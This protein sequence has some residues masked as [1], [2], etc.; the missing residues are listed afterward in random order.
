MR[1]STNAIF[2]KCS[3][4]NEH[5]PDK[6]YRVNFPLHVANKYAR[7][8]FSFRK[9]L[10]HPLHTSS[11]PLIRSHFLH[12]FT[13]NLR[14][15]GPFIFQ[16]GELDLTIGYRSTGQ[17]DRRSNEQRDGRRERT[18]TDRHSP[19]GWGAAPYLGSA[20]RG[21]GLPFPVAS[22]LCVL[23]PAIERRF[24]DETMII[25]EYVAF[26]TTIAARDITFILR[27]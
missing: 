8:T 15:L 10:E 3:N 22:F 26:R 6:I 11:V 24:V 14:S 16:T 27:S 4:F 19:Y 25:Y 5:F 18:N 20:K 12:V 9:H 13:E 17:M 1:N 23:E 7:H 2:Y 21:A